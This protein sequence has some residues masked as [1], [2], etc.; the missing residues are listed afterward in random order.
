LCFLLCYVTSSLLC[1]RVAAAFSV[2][3]GTNVL[4]R[5]GETRSVLRYRVHENYRP[6]NSYENDIAVVEVSVWR[7]DAVGRMLPT[8]TATSLA[9]G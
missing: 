9:V 6:E 2:L 7:R 3:S 8:A 4:S 1:D 5:G